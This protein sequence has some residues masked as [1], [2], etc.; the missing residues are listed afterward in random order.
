MLAFNKQHISSYLDRAYKF[1]MGKNS[2][3]EMK[4][5]TIL[6]N[7][8]A[9]ILK[10]VR[11]AISRQTDD[12]GLRDFATYAFPRFQNASNITKSIIVF[13]TLCALLTTPQIT[14]LVKGSLYILE[15]LIS[16]SKEDTMEETTQSKDWEMCESE[17]RRHASIIGR[18]SFSAYIQQVMQEV[19]EQVAGDGDMVG[20]RGQPILV[21]RH[22]HCPLQYL[23]CHFSSLEW[24]AVG[25]PE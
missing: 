18:S 10:A 6:H 17:D 7:C 9:H 11:Q 8:F 22:P 14:N 15:S 1:C 12:K 25:R 24:L 4:S 13:H 3:N 5:Y 2:W 19:K 16:R 20:K 21:S 23:P